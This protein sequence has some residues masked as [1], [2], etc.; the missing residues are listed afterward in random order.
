MLAACH[1]QGS[2]LKDHRVVFVGA[3]S[4]GCGIAN[5]IVAHMKQEGLS[6]AQA[7]SQIYLTSSKGLLTDDMDS[8]RDFQ[9][10]YVKAKSDVASW[11]Q[12]ESGKITLLDVVRETKPTILVGVSGQPGLMSEEIIKTMYKDCKKPIILPLSNPTSRVE[13]HPEDV[14]NWTEGNAIVATGSPFDPVKLE[15]NE[16]SI[17]QCNNSYIFPGIGLGV[18]A[19]KS[20]RVTEKMFMAASE[21]LASCSPLVKGQGQDLLPCLN[22]IREVSRII[23]VAVAKQA[24]AENVAVTIDD[25]KLAQRIKSNFWNPEYREYRR[26]SF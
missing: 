1:A 12:D 23:A 25:D 22:D 2:Q 10:D 15:G 4:A 26:T 24:M 8:L 21:A 11:N 5:Q 6:E 16:Y 14:L 9:K 3:G 18:L 13:A 20:K 19:A 17:A 7:H